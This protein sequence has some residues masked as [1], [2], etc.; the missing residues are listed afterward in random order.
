MSPHHAGAT[1]E[2]QNTRTWSECIDTT[3]SDH[4]GNDGAMA[5]VH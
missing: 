4:T 3:A 1:I 2:T 5:R